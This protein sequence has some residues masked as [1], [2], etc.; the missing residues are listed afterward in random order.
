M[1]DASAIL[2]VWAA[3]LDVP[4]ADVA[5]YRAT[6]DVRELARVDRLRQD[7]DKRDYIVSHGILRA[8]LAR[9]AAIDAAD[10]VF[11]Y[12][13]HG[14]PYIGKPGDNAIE[15]NMSDSKGMLLV[16]V[17]S[18][19]AVGVDIEKRRPIE[20]LKFARRFFTSTEADA[21]EALPESAREEAF[22]RT[23]T[24]KEG[25]VKGWGFGI[26]RHVGAFD[27]RVG[28]AKSGLLTCA[29]DETSPDR[30]SLVNIDTITGYAAT[31]AVETPGVESVEV[32]WWDAESE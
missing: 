11:R 10:I 18:G 28:E 22:F 5:R 3:R 25:Y 1:T 17:S 2:D 12:G 31:V 24:C 26:Q 7:V 21:I 27:V 14:K 4:D 15:F 19:V 30:W 16:A 23:W 9:Y 20:I 29:F 13:P 6:L 8:I 32:R